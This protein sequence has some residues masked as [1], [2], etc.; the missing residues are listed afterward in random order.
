M[1]FIK[2]VI[3]HFIFRNKIIPANIFMAS[4]LR[5]KHFVF[6]LLIKLQYAA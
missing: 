2:L 5:R 6:L 4:R 1:G 3:D